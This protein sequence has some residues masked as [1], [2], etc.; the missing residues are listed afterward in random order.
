M[1]ACRCFCIILNSFYVF[2]TAKE[3][4]FHAHPAAFCS[5][6][7]FGRGQYTFFD[8]AFNNGFSR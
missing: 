4:L 1:I 3:L 7:V 2:L 5:D 8:Q 6:A